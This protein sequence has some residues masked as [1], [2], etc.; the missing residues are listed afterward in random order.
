MCFCAAA[1]LSPQAG[2]QGTWRC[3]RTP[4]TASSWWRTPPRLWACLTFPGTPTIAWRNFEGLEDFGFMQKILPIHAPIHA[5]SKHKP[6]CWFK[7][8]TQVEVWRHQAYPAFAATEL[9]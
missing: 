3:G 7:M 1:H 6:G 5:A 8:T 4:V 2:R 9:G